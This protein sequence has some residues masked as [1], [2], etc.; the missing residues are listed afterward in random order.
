MAS[1]FPPGLNLDMIPSTALP[2]GIKPNFVNRSTLAHP[3]VAAS[4]TTSILAVV[5]LSVRLYATLRITRSASHDDSITILALVFSLAY[6]GY[7]L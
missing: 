6:V 5:L 4:A 2:P 1:S 3:I 7:V